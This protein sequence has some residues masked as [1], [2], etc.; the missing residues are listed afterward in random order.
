MASN[1]LRVLKDSFQSQS[2]SAVESKAPNVNVP[3]L[4]MGYNM[5]S[6]KKH[7]MA[8][9]TSICTCRQIPTITSLFHTTHP[10]DLSSFVCLHY[11]V[12]RG[13]PTLP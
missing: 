5:A 7:Q 10:F 4:M 1:P 9:S 2:Q 3:L 6:R 8:K 12:I 13:L 11:N